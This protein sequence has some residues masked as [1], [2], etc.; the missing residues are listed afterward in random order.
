MIRIAQFYARYETTLNDGLLRESG[1]RLL[2]F[3]HERTSTYFGKGYDDYGIVVRAQLEIGSTKAWVA[4]LALASFLSRYGSIREGLIGIVKDVESLARFIIPGI[5]KVIGLDDQLP[6]F[7]RRTFGVARRLLSLFEQV[8]QGEISA[9]EATGR[10]I[11]LLDLEDP[12]EN[13][14]E[15]QRLKD[16]LAAEFHFVERKLP[17]TT[18]QPSL[19]TAMMNTRQS[20]E[21]KSVPVR[22]QPAIAPLPGS[23][24]RRRRKGVI[25]TRNPKTGEFQIYAY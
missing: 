13:F 15:N 8:E 9:N 23:R 18:T 3:S 19:V 25:V 5:S 16:Q 14:E 7:H 2:R 22:R 20:P 6:S 21:H 10:A 4:I 12:T 1:E 11:R 17:N 24:G